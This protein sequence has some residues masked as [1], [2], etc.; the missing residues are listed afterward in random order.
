MSHSEKKHILVVDDN[1]TNLKYAT[2]ILTEYYRVSMAKSGEQ[3][4]EL[5]KKVIPDLILL[6]IMMP[7]MDGYTTFKHIKESSL[8]SSI[9]V[10]FLTADVEC[11]SEI[12]GLKMG[13][14]D[15]IKKP[16]EPEIML[17][18]IEKVLQ[19]DDMRKHLT[20]SA[21]K[22]ELTNLWN[23]HYIEAEI[24]K[25]ALS[26]DD[27]GVF[28][29]M[30]MDNFKAVND[31]FGH[32]MGDAILINMAEV[33]QKVTKEDDVICRMGG[34]EFCLFLKGAYPN[35]ECVRIAKE[36]I[37]GMDDKLKV[38]NADGYDVSVSIG[39][40]QMPDDGTDYSELYNKADKALYFVK[41]NGKKSY[42]FYKEK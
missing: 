23:R 1:T 29:M 8:T 34:D 18:R 30:D 25:T 28:M 6:D 37:A 40:A 27:R 33:L 32:M 20:L 21:Q 24:R 42:H 9:P 7:T 36:I 39:I 4:L 41:E 38:I 16:F 13:A 10:I 35:E 14:M 15:Y 2:N 3:A 26:D 22:D 19:I 11:E 31:N 12:K 5:L 17:S